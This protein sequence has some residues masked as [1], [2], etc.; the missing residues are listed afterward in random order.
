MLKIH[1]TNVYNYQR[2]KIFKDKNLKRNIIK[3]PAVGRCIT[4]KDATILTQFNYASYTCQLFKHFIYLILVDFRIN[5]VVR[6]LQVYCLFWCYQPTGVLPP[7]P[8]LCPRYSTSW[9]RYKVPLVIPGGLFKFQSFVTPQT[10]R[11]YSLSG[12]QSYHT[13]QGL[14]QGTFNFL[15]CLSFCVSQFA[16]SSASA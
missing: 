4:V 8:L 7:S 1:C 3:C 9:C 10:H 2:I 11:T 6:V 16:L 12:I 5:T 15:P 13:R 14:M